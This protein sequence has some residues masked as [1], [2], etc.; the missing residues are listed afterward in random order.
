MT[1]D[2]LTDKQQ[3]IYNVVSDQP[4][5]AYDLAQAAEIDNRSAGAVLAGLE[6]RGLVVSYYDEEQRANLWRRA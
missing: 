6:K 4:H 2:R 3:R 5:L 1:T